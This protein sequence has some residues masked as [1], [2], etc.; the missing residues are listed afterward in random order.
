MT[1]KISIKSASFAYGEKTVWKDIEFDVESGETLC[2]LGPN[3]CGKTTLL[4]CIHGNLKL[5]TGQVLIDGKDVQSMQAVEVAKKMG[6]VFQDHHASFPYRALEVV[7]MGRAP[8]LGIFQTPD[9][10]DSKMAI[11]I[12][13]EMGIGHL[14][15]RR[16]TELSGGERQ[17]VLIAQALCQDPEIIVFDEPT[18]HLDFKNQTL[19]LQ[20]INRLSKRGFT[21]VMTSHFPDHAWVLSS[22]VAMMGRGRLIAVG[23]SDEVMTEENLSE[24][25]GMDIKVY[26]DNSGDMPVR[27]CMPSYEFRQP[28]DIHQSGEGVAYAK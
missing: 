15:Y 7:K 23:S 2:L 25:Y 11:D 10:Q 4:N 16:Y 17:L 8:Y 22:K 19:V 24:T 1:A 13:E 21:I 27:F 18:S 12:M 3:G 26:E 9:A 14:A 6:Y 28:S 5:K 20:T